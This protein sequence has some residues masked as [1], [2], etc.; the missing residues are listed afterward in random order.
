MKKLIEKY[1][2]PESI[3]VVSPYPEKGE[4]YSA[5]KSGIASYAKNVVSKMDRRVIV[6]ADYDKKEEIYEEGNVLVWRCFK[7]NRIRMWLEIT[8]VMLKFPVV[9]NILVQLDFALYGRVLVTGL[10]IPFLGVLKVIGYKPYV[11]MHS[12]VTDILKLKGH[13]GLGND[14]KD[15]LLGYGYNLVFHLFYFLLGLVCNKIIVLEEALKKKISS[16]VKEDKVI[17]I[18]HGVDD[19]LSSVNKSEAREKLGLSKKDYVVLFFGFVNWFKGADRFVDIYGNTKEMLGKKVKF[20][21]AGGKSITLGERPFYHR[22]FSNVLD[23]IYY[24]QNMSITG[25]VPQEKIELFFS[26]CDLVVLPYRYFMTASGVFSLVFSYKKPFIVS[27]ELSEMLSDTEFQKAFSEVN[28]NKEDI[29]FDLNKKSCLK[30][31]ERVLED[32]LKDK[33]KKVATTMRTV[34]SYHKTAKIYS[35]LFTLNTQMLSRPVFKIE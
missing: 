3:I 27:R 24:S 33:M 26:A 15:N 34:R 13:V 21:I 23:K 30:V 18:P 8:R 16:L 32:G 17:V 9:K 11:T 20:I 31:T 10:I 7:K 12:V 6:L 14:L 5:G 29:I 4:V 1:N 2:N 35:D 22:Y 25:Y 19:N 28:L